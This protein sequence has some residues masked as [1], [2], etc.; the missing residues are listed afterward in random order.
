[1]RILPVWV[2]ALGLLG[3]QS[4][5]LTPGI[6]TMATERETAHII[7]TFIGRVPIMPGTAF[8]VDFDGKPLGLW[9]DGTKLDFYT[10][11]G[12]H[13]LRVIEDFLAVQIQAG[14]T[15]TFRYEWRGIRKAVLAK[16]GA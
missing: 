1:V 8:P 10:A 16:E 11:P 15:Q 14:E 12:V 4:P 7:V 9:R 3:C 5:G 2:L 6:P 13:T